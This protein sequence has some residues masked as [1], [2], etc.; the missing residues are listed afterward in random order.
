YLNISLIDD[1]IKPQ[2]GLKWNSAIDYFNEIGGDKDRF[3]KLSTDISAFGTPNIALPLTIALRLG[4]QTN[5]G[6]YK[7]Y[8]ANTI[9]NNENLRGFRNE[10]F[11]G[12]SAYYANSEMRFPV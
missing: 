4:A 9:G 7:F 1:K 2:T 5:I 11:S 10:R 6:D 3:V 12:K 8:Q